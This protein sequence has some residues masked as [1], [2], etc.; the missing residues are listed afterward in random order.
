[1]PPGTGNIELSSPV[2]RARFC[3][4]GLAARFAYVWPDPVPILP[5]A[6]ESDAAA[7][8]CRD[9][10]L[11]AAR[12]LYALPMD[13]DPA[14][15]PAPRLLRLD[16]DALALFNE[17][18]QEAMQ[19]ARSSRALGAGWHGKT[20]SRALRL[21]IIYELLAWAAGTRAE[22]RMISADAMA[23]VGRVTLWSRYGTNLT[24]NMPRIAAAV[25]ALPAERDQLNETH[26][27]A[28]GAVFSSAAATGSGGA[29]RTTKPGLR[30]V[31]RGILTSRVE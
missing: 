13:G 31:S 16:H 27:V 25:R 12:R 14:G 3:D 17:L 1:M 8:E 30:C 18:R 4:D 29:T 23:R 15:E 2:D 19:R 20:P 9:R 24:D 11:A 22:H 10:L 5:L 6:I 21:A 26:A 7:R 28:F